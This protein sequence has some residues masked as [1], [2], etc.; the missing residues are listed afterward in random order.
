MANKTDDTGY[1]DEC[2]SELWFGQSE[3]PHAN[4]CDDCYYLEIINEECAAPVE[5]VET[6]F[7]E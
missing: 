4:L 5:R 1:C 3:A 2:D 6:K 7:E